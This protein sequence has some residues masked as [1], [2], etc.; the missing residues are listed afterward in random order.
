MPVIYALSHVPP[1]VSAY[2]MAKYSRSK[3][4]MK[5]SL[6]DL[7]QQKA[8]AFLNTFYFSYGHASIADLAHVP[9]A[10]EQVSLFAAM[11]VVDEPLWDG[12]ERSTRYQDFSK[13]PFYTPPAA[14]PHYEKAIGSLFDLY[15]TLFSQAESHL[16]ESYPKPHDLEPALYRRTIRARAFDVARYALPLAA[17]TSLGQ[18][19]NARVLEQQIRRLMASPYAELREIAAGMKTAVTDQ[20]PFNLLES[21]LEHLGI[22]VPAA[23][24]N[25]MNPGPLAPTLTKYTDADDYM[26]Q[27][28]DN[29][30]PLIRDRFA[31]V[32]P[33]IDPVVLH[34]LTDPVLDM[35]A[36]IIY[37]ESA[38]SYHDILV[39]L[40]DY[41]EAERMEIIGDIL[42]RRGPHDAWPRILQQR[43]LIA[44]V[45]VDV[46]AFR[47]LNRHRRLDKV[48][49]RLDPRLGYDTPVELDQVGASTPYQS[50]LTQHYAGLASYSA[51]VLPYLLPLGHRRRI[52]LRLDFAEAAY[53][54]EL[55]SRSSG[56]FSYRRIAQALYQS[57]EK[58]YPALARAI[59]V[60]PL[61]VYDP[62][63]R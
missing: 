8:E 48:V 52:L 41:S 62:F 37:Q 15:R 24:S 21:R 60:T 57:I 54:I 16:G 9:L 5:D 34:S 18:V 29:I 10:I 56:H 46:G 43:P 6:L 58:T 27:V 38:L 2:G 49:Q 36:G 30:A 50:A 26:I 14:G 61:E 7:S 51:D 33:A 4:S 35:L 45:L 17:L 22:P 44:D 19:T 32:S 42:H 3:V 1:E 40:S 28:R 47:D 20:M 55:R 13:N 12:Q 39:R 31:G 63:E 59:R 23:I 53:L 11:E 25:E